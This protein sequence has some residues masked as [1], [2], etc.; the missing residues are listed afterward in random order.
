[1]PPALG[2]SRRGWQSASP[3]SLQSCRTSLSPRSSSPSCSAPGGFQMKTSPREHRRCSSRCS[4]WQSNGCDSFG[5]SSS[6]R[7]AS[8]SWWHGTTELL[9][10]SVVTIPTSI[11]RLQDL[12]RRGEVDEVA[13]SRFGLP[14]FRTMGRV[15]RS[16]T[17]GS[18]PSAAAKRTRVVTETSFE[19]CS[20]N[21]KNLVSK[22]ACSANSSWVS[23]SFSRPRRTWAA[24]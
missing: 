3:T 22:P 5:K 24:T 15:G 20:M 9:G 4:R 2:R 1:M 10:S 11:C 8:S 13:V 19:P 21:R 12:G 23:P 7:W 16:R 14:G 6:V 17:A 18:Q